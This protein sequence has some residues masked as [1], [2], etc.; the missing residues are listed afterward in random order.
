MIRL[1]VAKR[2]SLGG[3]YYRMGRFRYNVFVNELNWNLPD[4]DHIS[5]IEFDE[6][7]TDAA[8]YIVAVTPDE[9]VVGCARLVP[10]NAPNL[11]GAVFPHLIPSGMCPNDRDVW[12]LSRMAVRRSD[13]LLRNSDLARL[14][15]LRAMDYAGSHGAVS[16]VGVVSVSMERFYRRHGFSLRRIGSVQRVERE[17]VT[18]C[19]INVGPIGS[20]TNAD[21]NFKLITSIPLEP[22][23]HAE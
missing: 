4:V 15:F 10:T 5:R 12:E 7:D 21:K 14:I 2:A 8:T 11:L 22:S 6:F 18:A 9:S 16:V 1:I 20:E 23:R 3:L 19:A 13:I 17:L